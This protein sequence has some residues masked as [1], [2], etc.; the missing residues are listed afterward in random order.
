MLNSANWIKAPVET[1]GAAVEFRK[2]FKATKP[3]KSAMLYA[4]SAGVYSPKLNGKK[5]TD[6]VLMPGLTSYRTRLLYQEY[7]I[8]AL[9]ERNNVLSIGVAP[10]WGVGHYGYAGEN[11]V[12]YNN[13]ALNAKIVITYTDESEEIIL[14]DE[15]FETYTTNVTSSD[16]YHGETVDLTAEIKPLGNA[17]SDTVGSA[18]VKQ[19]GEWIKEIDRINAV[20]IIKT[21][22]G[23]YVVDFGQNLTGYVE[24]TAKGKRGDRIVL[25]HGEVLDKDGNYYQ[26]NLR[27]A[28]NENIFVLSGECDVFKPT[29]SF[30]GFRYVHLVECPEY[31]LDKK[32]FKAISVHSDM[33]RTG[34]FACGNE[35]IN[36]L[37]HNI[38]W[39]QKSNFLDIPTDC[40]QRDER[41]GWTG[42]AQVFCRTASI[43]YDT[44][45]FFT[46]WLADVAIEQR[47]DGAVAGVVP[48]PFKGSAV[49]RISAAWGDVA[50]VIPWELYLAYGNK[51]LLKKHFPMMKK[52]VEYLHSAGSEEYLWLGGMHYGDWLAM[53]AGADSYVGATSN[54]LIGS[55]FFAYSTSLLI[56]AGEVLG[57][58]MTE[59][60][61]LYKNVRAAFREYFMENGMPKAEFPLTEITRPNHAVVDSVREGMTQTALVLILHFGLCDECER[62]A[63]ENKLASMIEENGNRMTTGFVGTPY[64]LHVLTKAGKTDLAY[65][66]LFQEKNPSWLYSVTHGATTMWEHWNSLK[67]DGSFWSTDMNS[68]NH[69]AYGTVYDWIFSTVIGISPVD[70]APA[71]REVNVAPHPCRE[72]G[73]AKASIDSRSGKITSHW[74]YKGDTVYYEIEI[75]EGVTAHITLPGGYTETVGAGNYFFTE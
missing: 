25:H 3:V 66:L 53:D 15:S 34:R 49:T 27:K 58:D 71:Y 14:T 39:G 4:T 46:K 18:L 31:L 21:P 42:D 5:I 13:V 1:G 67:E 56:K 43:N 45:K 51:E 61:E 24:V 72:L 12:F 10:G 59:Y 28:R 60:R 30:Q 54:D 63:L 68:F 22:K 73:F 55:A 52:W 17:V 57:E 37:Y 29:Y 62:A 69:Y 16:I 48:H 7:D 35:K 40:P 70:S 9:I 36:Q 38:I 6:A 50:C 32:N 19:D 20:E 33:K 2:E 75:P 44:E 74:Y 23:E 64:I 47:A 11:R 41:L 8:T 26:A 65:K